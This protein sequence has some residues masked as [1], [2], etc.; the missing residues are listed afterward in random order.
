MHSEKRKGSQEYFLER[1][2]RLSQ[3]G[4]ISAFIHA[5]G[6]AKG[7]STLRVRTAG[8]LEYWV[9]PDRGMDIFECSW[10]GRSLCWHSP[11]AVVHPAYYS[12]RGVEWLRTFAGGLLTTCGL[13]AA[14]APSVDDGEDLGLHGSIANTPA[15]GVH[16]SEDWT[17]NDCELTV[18]GEVREVS[19]LGHNM[20][21]RRKITTSLQSSRIVLHDVVKNEGMR[22]SP[23]MLLYHFN[24]GYPLLTANSRIFAPSRQV[25]PATELA[26]RSAAQW[27]TF[28]APSFGTGERVYF[29]DMEASADG[30]V[31]IVLVSDQEESDFGISLR[32]SKAALPEFVQWKMPGANHYVLGL[33]PA[34]CRS[35]GRAAERARGTLKSLSPGMEREFR[36]E[37]QVLEGAQE[38][39]DAIRETGSQQPD[40]R[41]QEA[42]RGVDSHSGGGI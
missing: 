37:L 32:Y 39:Q 34:N 4:G 1:T 20:V 27:H 16:W 18:S 36:I 38:V 25:E 22:E 14:G 35:L 23:L 9:V 28:E 6:R 7:V 40:N 3:L 8:G 12:N 31:N 17:E 10:R 30:I 19:V 5:D 33:E 41:S 26:A 29:H 21:L 24:F 13:T 42:R 15:E 2:G 11:V